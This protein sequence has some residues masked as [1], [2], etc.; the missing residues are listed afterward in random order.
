M[1]LDQDKIYSSNLLNN[2]I[3]DDMTAKEMESYI[4]NKLLKNPEI[5]KKIDTRTNIY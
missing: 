2:A 1:K 3:N 4:L 5:E